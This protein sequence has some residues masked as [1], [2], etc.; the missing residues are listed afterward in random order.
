MHMIDFSNDRANMAYV[1]DE[2]WHGLGFK[3]NPDSTIEEWRIAAGLDFKLIKAPVL[4]DVSK[5]K[6]KTMDLIEYGD[7]A[8]IY[9]DD[10]QAPLSVVSDGYNVVQP[11]DILEF[12]RELVAA[13]G[14]FR[15]ETAG[16]LDGGRKIWVLA[17]AKYEARIVGQD[18]ILPYLLLAT[19]CDKSLATIGQFTSVRVVCQNTLEFSVQERQ[20]SRVRVPHTRE[21]NPEM[22]KE[23]LGLI[24]S[25][26]ST[27]E[28]EATKMAKQKL[29]RDDAVR[30]FFS[31]I[32]MDPEDGI[33]EHD[34]AANSQKV[35]RML[36]LYETGLG[37]DLKS[38]NGTVWGA[39]NAVTRYSDHESG[40]SATTRMNS[41][42]FGSGRK[43]K[44]RAWDEAQ[45]MV[46]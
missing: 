44:E 7:R 46:A 43:L 41:S 28:K 31:A 12:Y 29:S 5:P 15:I 1:G 8:V 9:R 30:F 25:S 18:L 34:I 22:I 23:E 35:K 21:F 16:S 37:S 11:D 33:E 36:T 19:S 17:R 24:G 20:G 38:A 6:A 39:V 27:F 4:F 42:W 10:T 13:S 45:K 2:P 26:F 32:G 3:V 14:E 40:R